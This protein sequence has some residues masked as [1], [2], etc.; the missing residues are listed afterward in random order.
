MEDRIRELIYKFENIT[1]DI[2]YYVIENSTLSQVEIDKI[3][4]L[5]SNRKKVIDLLE[6]E[7]KNAD[8]AKISSEIDNKI[9]QL[10]EEEKFILDKISA[11][12]KTMELKIKSVGNKKNLL[13][14]LKNT[15]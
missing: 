4:D 3:G 5:Y 14:Y 13:V 9:K 11:R 7:M 1:E 15:A 12:M 6:I 10:L 8:R 2:R